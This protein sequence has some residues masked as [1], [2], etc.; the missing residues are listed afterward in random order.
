MAV[1]TEAAIKI[2]NPQ[3]WTTLDANEKKI[4]KHKKNLIKK[5]NNTHTQHKTLKREEQHR[6]PPLH[7]R[8]ITQ[9]PTITPERNNTDSHHYTRE[10]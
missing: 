10:E 6:L 8:G 1:K 2:D 4:K 3:T 9:T 5:N 7:Q